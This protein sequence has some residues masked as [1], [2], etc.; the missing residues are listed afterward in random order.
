[1]SLRKKL[2]MMQSSSY[3]KESW[4]WIYD[5]FFLNIL[6]EFIWRFLTTKLQ[7][8]KFSFILFLYFS[9]VCKSTKHFRNTNI[10]PL[11]GFF[12]TEFGK[13]FRNVLIL[14]CYHIFS[15][16]RYVDINILI[17]IKKYLWNYLFAIDYQQWLEE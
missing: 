10:V 14:V 2:M 15:A 13:N 1:M 11:F 7:R 4:P 16:F 9:D 3:I 12:I 6:I 17:S 8:S 5:L